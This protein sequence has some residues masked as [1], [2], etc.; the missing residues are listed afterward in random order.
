MSPNFGPIDWEHLVFPTW[1]LVDWVRVYQPKGAHNIGCNP[2]DCPTTEYI[3]TYIEAYTNPN[4]TTWVDDYKR[5]I[6]K[7]R[8]VDNCT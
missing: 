4:L 1:I 5:P 6:P 8:L 2:P 3:N 7:N